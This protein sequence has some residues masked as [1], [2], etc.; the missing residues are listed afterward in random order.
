MSYF[1]AI[2]LGLI[3]GLTEFLPISSSGHLVLTEHLLGATMPG[4]IF[5][6]VV[7]FGTWMS[8]FIYFRKK[9]LR[10]IKS[11]LVSGLEA[12]RKL[13]LYLVIG[14]APLVIVAVPLKDSILSAFGSPLTTAVFLVVTGIILLLTAVVPRGTG[15]ISLR[16]AVVMGAGQALALFPG[17]S[18]SGT[19]ISAGLFAGVKPVEAAEFSFLLFLPAIGGAI[20]YRAHEFIN[21]NPSLIGQYIVGAVISFIAG[22]VAVYLLLSIIRKGKFKYFGIYCVIVGLIGIIYF[23]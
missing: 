16:N 15:K 9:V 3:Q 17:I 8:V 6:L 19:S 1:D 7:H 4:V 13:L 11:V 14:T 2:I 21:L 20:I 22:M 18:R 5:E 23:S 10:L 12:E